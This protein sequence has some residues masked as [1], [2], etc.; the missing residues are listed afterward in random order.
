MVGGIDEKDSDDDEVS[1]VVEEEEYCL[2]ALCVGERFE[3]WMASLMGCEERRIATS[4]FVKLEECAA[5]PFCIVRVP[6]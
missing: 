5:L 3:L 6:K 2:L 1:L 4:C